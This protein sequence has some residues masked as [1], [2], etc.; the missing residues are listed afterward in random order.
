M[1]NRLTATVRNI[2]RFE[3]HEKSSYSVMRDWHARKIDDIWIDHELGHPV[4]PDFDLVE[5][6]TSAGPAYCSA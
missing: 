3:L 6:G 5:Q 2:Y 4:P 1:Q